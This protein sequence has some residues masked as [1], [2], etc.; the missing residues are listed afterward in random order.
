ME[1]LMRIAKYYSNKDIRIEEIPIPRIGA[2]ELLIRVEA[3]GICGTDVLEWYRRD[4][5]PLILGHEISGVIE[6][7][8]RDLRRYKKGQRISASHHVPCGQCNYCRRGHQTVCETL[9]QTH[10]DPG[11]FAEYL[12]LPEDNVRLGGVYPLPDNLTAEEATFTEPLACVLRGQRIARVIKGKSVLVIGCGVSGLLHI[13]M[14]KINGASFVAASDIVDYRLQF[15][16]HL[17]LD[18][19]IDAREEDVPK[20]FRQLN[21]ARAADVVIV[22]TGAKSAHRTALQSVERAGSVLFFAATDEGVTV[23][24]SINDLFWRNEITLTSSYAAT[25]GEHLEAM[26]LLSA[27]KIHVKEMITHIFGLERIQDGF[28]LVA[29]AGD[30]LKVIVRPQKFRTAYS[31]NITVERR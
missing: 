1:Q 15:A 30:S 28:G 20:R 18:A 21:Q 17:G 2:G 29:K 7:V 22:A 13:Q 11:G 3:S 16:R 27:R 31:K 6:E 8:G 5:I 25:P 9:R 24:L 19:V 12:R 14:A 26:K 23:P 10:F 4:K